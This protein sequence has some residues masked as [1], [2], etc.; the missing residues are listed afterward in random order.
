MTALERRGR[1]LLLAYPRWY[2]R[3]RGEEM[4]GTLAAASPPG[5]R[6]PS[7]RDGRALV[8]GG[9]RVRAGLTRRLSTATSVRL[10]ALLGAA[11][12]L[13]WLTASNLSE[14]ILPLLGSGRNSGAAGTTAFALG[15]LVLVAAAWF[16]PRAVTA[17]LALAGAVVYLL[18]WGDRIMAVQPAGLLVLLAV[19]V[20]GRERLPRSWLWLAGGILAAS[21]V[22]QVGPALLPSHPLPGNGTSIAQLR[23]TASP[24][25]ALSYQLLLSSGPW[26]ILAAVVLWAAAVDARPALAMAICVAATFLVSNLLGYV[27]Y[28]VGGL[29]AWQWYLP[30]A[31]SAALAAGAAWRLRGQAVL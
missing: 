13:V 5:R 6:W 3:E 19:L 14:V 12:A 26:I 15:T 7:L 31:G 27:G 4:L 29:Q 23:A 24:W 18:F 25:P 17:V 21:L 1:W 28:N 20:L 10:A 9:L 2:R 16:A 30:A 8:M 22:A 11:L